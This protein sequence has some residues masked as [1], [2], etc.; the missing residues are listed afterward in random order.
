M[1]QYYYISHEKF[2][3]TLKVI[4]YILINV[5]CAFNNHNLVLPIY[6]NCIYF[7]NLV[8]STPLQIGF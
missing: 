4:F 7:A 8:S 1:T 6:V 3:S 5:E 2:P